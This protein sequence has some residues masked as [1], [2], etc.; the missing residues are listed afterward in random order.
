V[1]AISACGGTTQT[2]NA[3]ASPPSARPSPN[4]SAPASV[5]LPSGSVVP[6]PAASEPPVATAWRQARGGQWPRRPRRPH[7]DA[8]PVHPNRIP[9]RWPRR[10]DGVRRHLGVRPRSRHVAR[11]RPGGKGLR[12]ASGT[13]RSGS[14]ASV[15]VVWAGQAGPTAFFD[16]L[17]AYDPTAN[18][19]H[20]SRTT[21]RTQ[22][23]ATARVRRS[24]RTGGC[25]S[26]TASPR[27][28]ALL[29]YARL[30]LRAGTLDRRDPDGTSRSCAACMRAG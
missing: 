16:D 18:A 24:G 29:G 11:A 23:R 3:P 1:V 6:S 14:T 21:G 17:W 26:A 28:G 5:A 20:A 9:V 7:L 27:G 13:R 15:V 4:A 30:R 12:R 19:G 25:G 2:P 10:R 22:S 8:R